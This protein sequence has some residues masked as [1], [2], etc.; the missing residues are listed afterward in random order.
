MSEQLQHH[1]QAWQRACADLVALGREI[2][3]DQRHLP[4]DLEGWDVQDN[5][6]HT[7]HLEAVLAGAP[8]ET[9]EVGEKPHVKNLSGRYTEQGVLARRGRSMGEL[10][11]ELE[12]AVATRSADLVAAPPDPEGAPPRTPGGVP[13]DNA[14]LLSNRPLD[15]WM[16][17]QDIRRAIDRPGNYDSPAAAHVFDRF[18]SGLPMVVGKRVAAE[19]GTTVR[20][21]VPEAKR[22]WTVAVGADGRAFLSED[23]AGEAGEAPTCTITLPA[24]DFVVLCGGRR[25]PDRTTPAITGDEVL[26]KSVLA[27]L[28][29]TP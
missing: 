29:M 2:P 19:P 28:P 1:I 4:T 6:A 23:E 26:A 18:G 24:E 15:V 16:H 13:W 22:S 20:V 14:T 7:A 12:R 27:S 8:D 11:D 5:V 17:E 21:E 3:E 10:C 9:V 25:T